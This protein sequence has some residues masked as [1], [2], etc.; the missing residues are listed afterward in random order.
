V[1]VW[2]WRRTGAGLPS[3]HRSPGVCLLQQADS[4]YAVEQGVICPGDENLVSGCLW[5]NRRGRSQEEVIGRHF[6]EVGSAGAAAPVPIELRKFSL[7][8]YLPLVLVYILPI[9]FGVRV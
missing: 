4:K 1:G 3:D 6:G 8:H 5:E 9:P 7:G 2:S